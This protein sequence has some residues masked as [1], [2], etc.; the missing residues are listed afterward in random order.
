[1]SSN[2]SFDQR[3]LPQLINYTTE[4]FLPMSLLTNAASLVYIIKYLK[5]NSYVSTLLKLD[6][7]FKI[8]S[9][10][11]SNIGLF[12]PS[13]TETELLTMCSLYILGNV[14]T[15]MSSYFFQPAIAVVRYIF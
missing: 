4:M 9:M 11:A 12:Y 5:V 8:A 10:T 6:S 1:M 3:D 13:K 14:A 15:I 2:T 7:A